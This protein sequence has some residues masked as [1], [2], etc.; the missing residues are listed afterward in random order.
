MEEFS[1]EKHSQV[2]AIGAHPDD[3]EL[4]TGGMLLCARNLGLSTAL[5]H[6]TS[7]EMGTRGDRETRRAEAV[8]AAKALG[9]SSPIF[10]D[11]PDGH[12]EV[13]EDAKDRVIRVIRDV[14]PHTILAP[15]TDDL[16]PD[17]E[18][19][20]KLVRKA[21]FLSGLA[22]WD[23]GQKPW[24]A[25]NLL[26]YF[27]H[28]VAEPSLVVDITEVF[29]EKKRACEAYS[30]QFHNPGSPQPT[31]FIAGENFW[32]WWEGRALYWGHF[33]GV[34]YGEPLALEGPLPTRNPFEFFEGFGKYR[35]P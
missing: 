31:T 13:T 15:Y 1:M 33:I 8:N 32:D 26:Y 22:R 24:R 16:H 17:H 18:A 35:N 2:L 19:A 3:V 29:E 21:N 27:S 20:G 6:L 12:L 10:L 4:N 34:R 9:S 23:T 11:L 30:S 7:G 5:C 25:P 28:T 14:R